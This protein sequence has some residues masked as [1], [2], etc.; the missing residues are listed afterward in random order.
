M[1]KIYA[2]LIKKELK[3]IEEVPEKIRGEVRNILGG[4]N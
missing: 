3:T 2:A 1:E 4:D